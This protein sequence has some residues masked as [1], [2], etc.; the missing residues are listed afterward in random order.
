MRTPKMLDNI[1]VVLNKPRYPENIGA[2]ARAMRNMG[3]SRLVVVAPENPDPERIAKM[4]THA[5]GDVV[6]A[7]ETRDTLKDALAPFGYVIGTT[8]RMG[9]QRNE[10]IPPREMA[11]K[12]VALAGENRVALVFGPEDR[13][14]TNEELSLCRGFVHIPTASFSSLNLSQAVMVL[15]HE[16]FSAARDPAPSSEPRLASHMELEKMY[17]ELGEFFERVGFNNPEK[18]GQR[19]HGFRKFLGRLPLRAGE[20]RLLRSFLEQIASRRA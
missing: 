17:E 20:V 16:V 13:G 2:A 1:A 7:M 4:A 10:A 5:A 11:R 12:V 8:A 9:R 18:P 19:L 14:L 3:L 15:C 6:H